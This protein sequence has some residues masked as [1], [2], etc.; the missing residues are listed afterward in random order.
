M[1]RSEL[2]FEGPID[3]P[4]HDVAWLGSPEERVDRFGIMTVLF[5]LCVAFFIAALWMS[6]SGFQKC[7]ALENATDRYACYDK[8]RDDL[9]KPPAKG[10][11]IPK[12]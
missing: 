8:L 9:S 11:N 3:K 1:Q 5:V 6:G 2:D 10:A 12:G 4:Q 7:S